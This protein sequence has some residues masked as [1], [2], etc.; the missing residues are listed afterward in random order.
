MKSN[1]LKINEKDNVVIATQDIGE[2][3][4]VVVDGMQL[5]P[6]VD[7]VVAGHKIARVDIGRGENI[8]RYGEPIVVAVEAIRC[9][10]WIHTHNTKPIS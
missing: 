6:A 8:F 9:G 7:A 10:Q 1:A 5:F 2:D 3:E 4:S